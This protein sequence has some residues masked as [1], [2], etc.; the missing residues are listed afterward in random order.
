[1]R[2]LFSKALLLLIFALDPETSG[3]YLNKN[4]AKELR[5]YHFR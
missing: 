2:A 3:L 4:H 5:F 1:M